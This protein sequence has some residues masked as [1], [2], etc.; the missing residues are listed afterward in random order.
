[1][2]HTGYFFTWLYFIVVAQ[3][4]F[5]GHKFNDNSRNFITSL[6]ETAFS[7]Q[8]GITILYWPVIY[9]GWADS[10]AA[11]RDMGV[12]ALPLICL[13]LDFVFC[14]YAFYIRRYLVTL[15]AALVY[16]VILCV[17]S[18]NV[19]LVYGMVDWVSGLSWG[20]VISIPAIHLFTYGLGMLIFK[21]IKEKRLKKLY[22]ED[23]EAIHEKDREYCKQMKKQGFTFEGVE[24]NTL[25][26]IK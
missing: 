15:V 22:S 7:F 21:C 3:D 1:M 5:I 2:T 13:F 26:Q 20:L 18:L 11:Y 19:R 12:H 25:D 8:M 23:L 17:Y 16:L 14:S 6:F 9:E 4:Y 10:V 24:E